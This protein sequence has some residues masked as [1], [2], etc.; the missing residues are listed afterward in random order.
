M[1]EAKLIQVMTGLGAVEKGRTNKFD[2]YNFRGIDDLYNALSPQLIEHGV[3]I[4]P[5][6]IDQWWDSYTTTG[7]KT[8]QRVRVKVRYTF[9]DVEKDA[10]EIGG[11]LSAIVI[12]EGSDRG[13]KAAN[14]AMTAAFKV[15]LFQVLC[16]PT[17]EQSDSEFDS[18]D[19][20]KSTYTSTTTT[21]RKRKV[22]DD[23]DRDPAST[24]PSG[25]NGARTSRRVRT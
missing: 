10:G 3:V 22:K 13:D 20:G 14:K 25:S 19:D 17:E 11:S 12:G 1:I 18:Q 4:Y 9:R 16:I 8:E 24:P 6:V 5:E 15:A 2:K 7:G 21:V 23:D